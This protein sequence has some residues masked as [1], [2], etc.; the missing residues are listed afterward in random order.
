MVLSD[1]QSCRCGRNGRIITEVLGRDDD[2]I[3]T[4][5][6][7]FLGSLEFLFESVGR[8]RECQIIQ[9]QLSD[10]VIRVVPL[11]GFTRADE[12]AM[13]RS[14]RRMLGAGVT[15]HID[16]VPSIP[17]TRSGKVKYVVSRVGKPWQA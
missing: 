16:Q 5:D 17:R 8:I 12:G 9:E 6:G 2:L 15:V 3:V 4:P 13:V 1:H 10:F 14:A 11:A 7:R